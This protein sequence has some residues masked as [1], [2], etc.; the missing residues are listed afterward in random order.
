[1][2]SATWSPVKRIW[3]DTI[4]L[5]AYILAGPALIVAKTLGSNALDRG[6]EAELELLV[7]STFLLVIGQLWDTLPDIPRATT[8][9]RLSHFRTTG[10]QSR[11]DNRQNERAGQ[12]PR[13]NAALAWHGHPHGKPRVHVGLR[14]L[15]FS[16][17]SPS[18]SIERRPCDCL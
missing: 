17:G 7:A 15:R 8:S 13:T 2:T 5:H 6:V 1:M 12:K 14:R 18:S 3:P 4:A 9:W 16:N 11:E 10:A